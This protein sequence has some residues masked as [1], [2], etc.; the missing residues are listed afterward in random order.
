MIWPMVDRANT[1]G[2]LQDFLDGQG[3]A[4][5][6]CAFLLC[7]SWNGADDALE[8]ALLRALRRGLDPNDATTFE[9]GVRT[10]MLG[11]LRG[12][13]GVA[14]LVD[15]RHD[16][17]E[18][19]GRLLQ[20]L[21]TLA[22][23]PRAVV[24]LTHFAH[25]DPRAVAQALNIDAA[26]VESLH[27]QGIRELAEELART[28]DHLDSTDR[29]A[30]DAVYRRPGA[31]N[32]GTTVENFEARGADQTRRGTR[33]RRPRRP[34]PQPPRR[35]RHCPGAASCPGAARP[36]VRDRCAG[37]GARHR[38]QRLVPAAPRP[39]PDP[40]PDAHPGLCLG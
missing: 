14:T 6:Q 32:D 40:Q 21:E 30:A 20:A 1:I 29:R 19:D 38:V 17:T 9:R 24:V 12:Q 34:R 2:A 25:L 11:H 23:E 15:E 22:F 13:I 5:R 33:P 3:R 8:S 28:G 27:Q 35:R 7:S 4:L 36:V 10:E 16:A 18:P 37:T 26:V 39:R 31:R